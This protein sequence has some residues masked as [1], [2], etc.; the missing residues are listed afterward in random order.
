[1]KGFRRAVGIVALLNIVYFAVEFCVASRAGSV[2]L[3]ADSLDF[4]EDASV[5]LL[6]L[7][8]IGWTPRHRAQLAMVLSM[9]L[10][11]PAVA[12]IWMAYVKLTSFMSPDATSLTITGGGALAVN[13][14]CAIL[15]TRYRNHS[16]SLTRA[17]FLSARNDALAN[18]AIIGAGLITN[19]HSTIW[20][21]LLVGVG[22]AVLNADSARQIWSAA[23][24]EHRHAQA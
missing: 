2:S 14:T 20:P 24:S 21:D 4:F 10:L 22:I 1:L 6:I 11:A 23:R 17:A 9:V 13:V 18:I 5:N 12:G 8:A 19:A 16:G 7:L 3:F 15:L